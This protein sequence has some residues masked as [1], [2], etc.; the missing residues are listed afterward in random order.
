VPQTLSPSSGYW[1]PSKGSLLTGGWLAVPVALGCELGLVVGVVPAQAAKIIAVT[2]SNASLD[3]H[4][5][6]RDILKIPPQRP[7]AGPWAS[8]CRELGAS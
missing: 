1:T 5:G 8:P 7:R 4:L 3:N 6:D 2:A